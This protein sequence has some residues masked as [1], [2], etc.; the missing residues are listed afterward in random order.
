MLR[1][2][3]RAADG[4]LKRGDRLRRAV[5]GE[6]G[7]AE[8]ELGAGIV[9]PQPGQSGAGLG[10]GVEP[11]QREQ[12][13]AKVLQRVGEVRRDFD[14]G[15]ERARRGLVAAGGLVRATL[16]VERAQALATGRRDGRDGVVDAQLSLL[17]T[18]LR[19]WWR[20][21]VTARL[22]PRR[23]HAAQPLAR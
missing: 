23:S 18:W 5:G 10:R 7:L 14:G 13:A 4:C 16:A 21:A 6:Q 15:G 20:G 1:L 3:R 8:V 9:R 22:K 17:P 12:R 11:A 19:P 2:P